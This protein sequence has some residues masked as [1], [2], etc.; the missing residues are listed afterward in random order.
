LSAA[1]LAFIMVREPRARGLEH[2]R[3]LQPRLDQFA[4]ELS[5]A[6]KYFLKTSQ[7]IMCSLLSSAQ[8]PS[9]RSSAAVGEIG[10]GLFGSAGRAGHLA[11]HSAKNE[12]WRRTVLA[13]TA[14]S[15]VTLVRTR[16][17]CSK[18]SWADRSHPLPSTETS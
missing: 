12:V 1:A 5:H 2:E 8:K 11:K 16:C 6:L 9:R 4:V 7:P 13:P 3:A 14:G 15:T 10:L 17:T 18:V